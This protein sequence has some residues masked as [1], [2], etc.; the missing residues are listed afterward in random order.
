M[1][2][3]VEE[4]SDEETKLVKRRGRKVVRRV[5]RGVE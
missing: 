5:G 4:R 2:R 3:E 1:R